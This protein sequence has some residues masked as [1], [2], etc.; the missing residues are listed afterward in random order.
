[1]LSVRVLLLLA[2]ALLLSVASGG[3]EPPR[4]VAPP[5]EAEASQVVE[6]MRGFSMRLSAAAPSDGRPDA[7]QLRR[8]E[9]IKSLRRLGAGALPALTRALSDPEVQMRRNAALALVYLGGGHLAEARPRL[10]I[11]G[12]MP[13]L[14][15]ATEDEDADVRAWAAH[16]L[17]EMGPGA[18]PAVRALIRLLSDKEEG[19]RNTS[20]LALGR[21]GPAAEAALPALRE[22][23]H[24]PSSDVR[25]FARQAIESIAGP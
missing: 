22:A 11:N 8:K 6:R 24:D 14:I 16:A 12:A 9:I 5:T 19:A 17:A 23:L 10:D 4:P 21:I 20:C 3:Q 1:M 2:H 15:R 7:A 13:G 25:G 18:A